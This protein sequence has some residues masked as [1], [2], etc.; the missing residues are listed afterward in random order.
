MSLF[1]TTGS[2]PGWTRDIVTASKSYSEYYG[3]IERL[4][5]NGTWKNLSDEYEKIEGQFLTV[6]EKFFFL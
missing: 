3:M 2:K 5:Q 4:E 1:T 6:F